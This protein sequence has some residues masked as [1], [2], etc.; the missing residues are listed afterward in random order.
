MREIFRAHD[1]SVSSIIYCVLYYYNIKN[2]KNLAA[3]VCENHAIL[4]FL[5]HNNY[6]DISEAFRQNREERGL[7]PHELAK[8][9]GV[10]H[11]NIYRWESGTVLPGIEMCVK[12]ADYYGISLDDLI[13]RKI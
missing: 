8:A 10:N 12:I 9:L 7:N 2:V 1:F 11:Q 3:Q 5:C 13:G 4:S 6:M